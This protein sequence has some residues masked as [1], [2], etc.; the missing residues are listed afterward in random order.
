MGAIGVILGFLNFVGILY[1]AGKAV[2]SLVQLNEGRSVLVEP[3]DGD[4]RTPEMV[5]SF[6]QEAMSQLFTW[7]AVAEDGGSRRIA[8]KGVEVGSNQKNPNPNLAGLHSLSPTTLEKS[9]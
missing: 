8:D 7:N 1:V 3:V 6:L 4:Y 5:S 9:F 2:P